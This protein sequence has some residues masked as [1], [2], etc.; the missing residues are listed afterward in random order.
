MICQDSDSGPAVAVAVANGDGTLLGDKTTF[1]N[2]SINVKY[3]KY[4]YVYSNWRTV[5]LQP[6]TFNRNRPPPH[7]V[8]VPIHT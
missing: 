1:R 8:L 7:L 2:S 3:E 6:G 5:L 4:N